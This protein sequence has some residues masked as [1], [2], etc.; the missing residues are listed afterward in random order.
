MCIRPKNSVYLFS[1]FRGGG[2]NNDGQFHFFHFLIASLRECSNVV[3]RKL[4]KL[5]RAVLSDKQVINV[6]YED[7]EKQ[8]EKGELK[9]DASNLSVAPAPGPGE[10]CP[11][12]SADTAP[13]PEEN[14][15]QC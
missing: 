1:V 6:A 9:C 4:G 7:S 5:D 12:E 2:G 14:V 10:I 13:S 15:K 3:F 11:A 8:V